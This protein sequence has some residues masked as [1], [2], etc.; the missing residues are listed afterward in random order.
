MEMRV[1]SMDRPSLKGHV[2]IIWKDVNLSS[3]DYYDTFAHGIYLKEK[4]EIPYLN[5]LLTAYDLAHDDSSSEND[6][7]LAM[8]NG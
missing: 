8:A 6:G 2:F 4:G 5:D 3:A 7:M 1:F